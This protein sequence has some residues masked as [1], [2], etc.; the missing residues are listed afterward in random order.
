VAEEPS[1]FTT[2]ALFSYDRVR[3]LRFALIIGLVMF[4]IASLI[5]GY[6]FFFQESD[7][8]F[9]VILK[10]LVTH[11]KTEI[12]AATTLGILYTV[13][14][15]GLVF[16]TVPLEVLF[17]V[18]LDAGVNPFLLVLLYVG[19][20]TLAF[21]ANYAIGAKLDRFTKLVVTP[22]KFYKTKGVINRR[23]AA[24]I[25]IFNLIPA[26]PSQ[27]LSAILGMF[28]YHKTKFYLWCISGQAVKYVIIALA[29]GWFLGDAIRLIIP[30]A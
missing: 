23:G 27:P 11:V 26:F 24:A 19:G 10:Q 3:K 29:Y 1:S 6:L 4:L 20:I 13:L 22:E 12:G 30:G 28:R 15:G 14:F 9:F 5:A 8:L 7:L 2:T 16:T 18:F 21:T 17:L 25:F